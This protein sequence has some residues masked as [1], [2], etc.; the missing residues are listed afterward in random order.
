[1]NVDLTP[2]A[3][4]R[5]NER[6]SREKRKKEKRPI[7]IVDPVDSNLAISKQNSEANSPAH[8]EKQPKTKFA[9]N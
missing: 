9:I 3:M 5:D 6:P 7:A 4:Y 8:S 1:M 2:E